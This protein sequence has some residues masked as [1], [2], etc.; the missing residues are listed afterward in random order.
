[1]SEAVL[2]VVL[3]HGCGG[4]RQATY[5]APGWIAALQ[6]SGRA[7]HVPDLPGHGTR[8]ASSDPD[9]YADLAGALLPCLPA[10]PFM[11]VGYSLGAKLLLEIAARDPH[12]VGKAVLG[13]LGDNLF[14][15]ESVAPAAAL[16][17][18][19]GATADTPPPVREFLRHW[20]GTANQASAVAAVLRRPANPVFTPQRLRE[21][22][23]PILLVN[24]A[25]DPVA[26]RVEQLLAALPTA[27]LHVLPGV[28]HFDLP[29]Q[30]EF[31]RLAIAFLTHEDT[32]S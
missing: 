30:P 5:E 18:E 2:P 22:K 16:A 28:S 21:V 10:G 23:M 3:L 4:T 20:N 6:A 17:L 19:H 27:Q 11:A 29:V 13:G 7:V 31:Q 8:S 14:A 25:A 26:S 1:V 24:G 9:D 32:Q 15:P 12:R